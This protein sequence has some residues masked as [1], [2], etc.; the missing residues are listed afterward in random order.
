MK[1]EYTPIQRA[2][3]GIMHQA[4]ECEQALKLAVFAEDN[5][6]P[7]VAV[8]LRKLAAFHSDHAFQWAQSLRA[9][10]GAA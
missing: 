5:A 10:G 7:D 2:G 8:G 1:V 9:V 3:L 4:F 6:M